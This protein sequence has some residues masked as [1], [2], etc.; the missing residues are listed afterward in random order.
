MSYQPRKSEEFAHHISERII[1]MFPTPVADESLDPVITGIQ[2]GRLV[3]V[4]KSVEPVVKILV[5]PEGL[6][7]FQ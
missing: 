7:A 3:I 1:E 2:E 6:T 5:A 4:D